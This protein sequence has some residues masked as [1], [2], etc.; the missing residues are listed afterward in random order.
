MLVVRV[1]AVL[2]EPLLVAVRQ[3]VQVPY[4]PVVQFVLGKRLDDVVFLQDQLFV[5]D[6]LEHPVLA[7]SVLVTFVHQAVLWVLWMQPVQ[8]AQQDLTQWV[9]TDWQQLNLAQILQSSF[10]VHQ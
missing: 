10:A 4:L 5:V 9:S 1:V 3:Q 6:L 2:Q 8:Q 7:T